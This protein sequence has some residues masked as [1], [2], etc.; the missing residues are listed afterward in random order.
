MLDQRLLAG[1]HVAVGRVE[2][3]EERLAVLLDGGARGAEPLPELVRLVLREARAVLLV[4]LPAREQLVELGGR[5][6]PL[7]L[8]RVLRRERLGLLDDARALGDRLVER[9]LRLGLLLLGELLG[10]ARERLEAAGECVEVADGVGPGDRLAEVG[11]GLGD[12][13]CGCSATRALLE[14]ADLAREIG[15]LPLEVGERLLRR[16]VGVL[17]DL[18][19]AVGG[20]HEDGARLVDAAPRLLL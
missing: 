10:G 1:A 18:P 6:L 11:H 2:F 13:R 8:R 17:A 15:V 19:L 5:L 14:Q 3:G 20:A 4:L 16:R 7:R 12:I 9:G